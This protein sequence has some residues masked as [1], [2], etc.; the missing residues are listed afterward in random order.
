MLKTK[1]D[2]K[3]CAVSY[4]NST[5]LND[6]R[7]YLDQLHSMS[8]EQISPEQFSAFVP[9]TEYQYINLI[10]DQ[11]KRQHITEHMDQHNVDRFTLVV[12]SF[13]VNMDLVGYGC[14]IYPAVT[15]YPGVIIENDVL[16]HGTT[17]ISHNSKIGQGSFISGGV[18]ISGS[19]EI[20]RHCWLAVKTVSL[21]HSL[22]PD[23]SKTH[24]R[25]IIGRR[26]NK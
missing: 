11:Q 4:D 26:D 14:F 25:S 13:L 18:S 19:T 20:G 22:L 7:W 21:D 6:L 2:K 1:T 16:I 10:T 5:T 24:V 3:L 17:G 23:G 9:S 12:D 8:V 15:L